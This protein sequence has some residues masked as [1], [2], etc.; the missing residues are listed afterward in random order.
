MGHRPEPLAGAAKT[1]DHLIGNQQ[2]V[3]LLQDRLDRLEIAAGRYQHSAGAH[4]W[5]GD[6]RGNRI[7]TFALNRCFQRSRDAG[8]KRLF[9]LTF[10]PIA[11]VVW[12][13]GV[14]DAVKRQ[15]KFQM[16]IGQAGQRR[17]HHGDAVIGFDA[18]NDLLLFRAAKRVVVIPGQLDLGIVGL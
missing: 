6:H 14:N 10:L 16:G 13:I 8:H 4:H 1:V 7:T 12:A 11:V 15:V 2:N 3:V 9:A 5:F 17:R 18:R